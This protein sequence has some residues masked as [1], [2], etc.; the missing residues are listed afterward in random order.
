M[1]K[2]Y[3]NLKGFKLHSF[4]GL[5][6]GHV[7]NLGMEY[8]QNNYYANLELDNDDSLVVGSYHDG[9]PDSSLLTIKF[10]QKIII[11]GVIFD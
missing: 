10:E 1:H 9:C 5:G 3:S 4:V 6:T 7:T 8:F 11:D 2:I